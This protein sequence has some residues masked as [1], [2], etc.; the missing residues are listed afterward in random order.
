[1][2]APA[3][4]AGLTL[5]VSVAPSD[6]DVAQICL[7]RNGV[8]ASCLPAAPNQMTQWAIQRAPGE[9]YTAVAVDASGNRSLPSAPTPSLEHVT[10][11]RRQLAGLE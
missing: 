3:L 6:A 2:M 5:L 4:F 9:V 11:E 1:M 7:Q 10:H 8:D